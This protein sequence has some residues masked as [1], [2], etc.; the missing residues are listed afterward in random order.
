MVLTPQSLLSF[1]TLFFLSL[2]VVHI[3][4]VVGQVLVKGQ[5]FTDGLAIIDAPAPNTTLHAGA[6]QSVAIDISGDGHLPQSASIPG[7]GQSTRFDSLEVYLV[8]YQTS[9]N[10][11]VSQGP[12]LLTQE[13]G[14]TVKHI[15]WVIDPCVAPGNYNLTFYEGSHIQDQA[16]FIITPLPIEIQNTNVAKSCSNGTNTLIPSP[17]PSSAPSH[18]PWLDGTQT[19]ILPFPSATASSATPGSPT[20]P[21]STALILSSLA[22]TAY[23]V[24]GKLLY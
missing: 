14:S 13:S 2:T 20:A 12:S 9:S 22:F 6:T 11:T 17:Q 8:S 19:S 15:N 21:L 16:F 1:V 3:Q 23:L 5:I 18:S 10:L 7:S 4:S 24:P